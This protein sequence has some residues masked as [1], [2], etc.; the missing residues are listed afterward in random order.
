MRKLAR[1]S[2]LV[3]LMLLPLVRV[4]DVRAA[5]IEAKPTDYVMD[6]AGVIEAGAAQRLIGQLRELEQKTGVQM[7][8]LTVP[9]TAGIPIEGYAIERAQKWGLGQKGKDNGLLM[10]VAVNDRAYRFEVGYGLESVI[11]DSLAGSIGRQYLV[12]RFKQGDYS[13][14]ISDASA[15]LMSTIAQAYGVELTG[16]ST[17]PARRSASRGFKPGVVFFLAVFLLSLFFSRGSRFTGRRAHGFGGR[18]YGGSG[19]LGGGG[20]GGGFGGFGGGGGGGF[21]GGGASG[22]W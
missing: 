11:P 22:G 3:L 2:W 19:G 4:S 9:S 14:G 5:G 17:R 18:W 8:V 12:P 16:M 1:L 15:V 21:G 20:F 10:V 13:G 6:R 7:I